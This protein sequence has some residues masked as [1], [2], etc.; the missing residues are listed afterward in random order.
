MTSAYIAHDADLRNFQIIPEVGLTEVDG[1]PR[2]RDIEIA[3]R[4]GYARPRKIREL[5][6]ANLSEIE[7]FG[8]APRRRAP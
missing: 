2:A 4:L 1:E 7:A 8:T 3:E 5:I 6:E